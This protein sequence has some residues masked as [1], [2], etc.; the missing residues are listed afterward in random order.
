MDCAEKQQINKAGSISRPEPDTYSKER[1]NKRV[2]PV[3][4]SGA[5]NI[6]IRVPFKHGSSRIL[7]CQVSQTNRGNII[8]IQS[9]VYGIYRG[10]HRRTGR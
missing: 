3:S 8:G 9:I 5:L 10:V 4:S 7:Q 6:S 1:G 2:I